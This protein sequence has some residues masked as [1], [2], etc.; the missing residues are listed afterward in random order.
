MLRRSERADGTLE[1]LVGFWLICGS[2]GEGGIAWRDCELCS[3][4]VQ[5]FF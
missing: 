2:G 5:F 1:A 3:W 4:R